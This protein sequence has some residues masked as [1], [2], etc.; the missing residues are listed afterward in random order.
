MPSSIQFLMLSVLRSRRLASSVVFTSA[1]L[2]AAAGTAASSCS[3]S[4]GSRKPPSCS[5]SASCPPSRRR[6]PVN[7]APWPQRRMRALGGFATQPAA[8]PGPR[9]GRPGR[10]A[11]AERGWCAGRRCCAASPPARLT[12]GTDP[13]RAGGARA[14]R[15]MH[16]R[17]RSRGDS[18]SGA[19]EHRA[20]PV[21]AVVQAKEADCQ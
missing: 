20:V 5:C 3:S 12:G 11:L 10:G 1:P 19:I 7:W 8:L 14:A 6:S 18:G 21:G 17:G 16:A 9:G 2:A 15:C 13:G 4:T